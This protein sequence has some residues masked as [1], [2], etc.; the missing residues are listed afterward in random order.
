[1]NTQSLQSDIEAILPDF[2]RLEYS[3]SREENFKIIQGEFI[4]SARSILLD[5]KLVYEEHHWPITALELYFYHP[6]FWPDKTTHFDSFRQGQQLEHGTWYVHRG[7]V[8]S[9]NRTGIDITAGSERKGI[10]A[11]LLIS[12][13]GDRQKSSGTAFKTIIRAG[14]DFASQKDGKLSERDRSVIEAINKKSVFKG[15]LTLQR[16][17]ITISERPPLWI[18]PRKL[19]EKQKD[20]AFGKRCLRIAT[21]AT[22]DPP[23][24]KLSDE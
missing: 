10:A 8:L 15:A 2:G 9:P 19:T 18:G 17:E 7:G 11:G 12:A 14:M 6:I 4:R 24:R 13:I 23:M 3:E 20:D 16:P 1:M 22:N 5:G 21:F